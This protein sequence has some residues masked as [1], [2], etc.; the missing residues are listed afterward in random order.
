MGPKKLF[1]CRSIL[2]LTDPDHDICEGGTLTIFTQSLT[3][4]TINL[5]VVNVDITQDVMILMRADT[6]HLRAIGRDGP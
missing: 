5:P 4:I 2:D 6:V 1:D 3:N